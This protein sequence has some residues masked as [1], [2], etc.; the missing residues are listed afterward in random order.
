MKPLLSRLL[1]AAERHA[2]DGEPA[3]F[4]VTEGHWAQLSLKA[5]F[6]KYS[7][8]LATKSLDVQEAAYARD[9]EAAARAA[10]TP[11]NADSPNGY[12]HQLAA[13]PKTHPYRVP[14]EG[15]QTRAPTA[16]T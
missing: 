9:R 16:P 6:T 11:N 12:I 2:V 4:E 8:H 14:Y 13:P 5:Y 3:A 15:P 7:P 1:F 10:S